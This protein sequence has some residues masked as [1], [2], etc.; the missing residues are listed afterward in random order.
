MKVDIFR[1]EIKRRFFCVYFIL[2]LSP[3]IM[4]SALRD[5]KTKLKQV[6]FPV[7]ADYTCL[8]VF[9]LGFVR[10]EKLVVSVVIRQ[11]ELRLC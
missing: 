2:Q 5:C 10:C 9:I 1:T 7:L 6:L 11:K 4:F 8:S 3:K